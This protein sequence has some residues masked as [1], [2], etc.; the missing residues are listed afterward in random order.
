MSRRWYQMATTSESSRGLSCPLLTARK[1]ER[2]SGPNPM[3]FLHL[4]AAKRDPGAP[5]SGYV[6]W[7]G[8]I[9]E[10]APF[11]R[12]GTSPGP[13]LQHLAGAAQCDCAVWCAELSLDSTRFG[14]DMRLAE[15]AIA[16]GGHDRGV[17]EDLLQRRQRSA[18]LKPPTGERVP[19]LVSVEPGDPRAS[20]DLHREAVGVRKGKYPPHAEP[21]FIEQR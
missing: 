7:D 11:N 17:P 18:R 14:L 21:Q 13:C 4:P 5:D 6:N 19:K 1:Q 10:T 15:P 20:P 3:G 16:L 2:P 8:E 12:S 9:F